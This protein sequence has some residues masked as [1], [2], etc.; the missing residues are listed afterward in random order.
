M[1]LIHYKITMIFFNWEKINKD[2]EQF[3]E[4]IKLTKHAIEMSSLKLRPALY[5]RE[6][7]RNYNNNNINVKTNTLKL[8]ILYVNFN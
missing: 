1:F 3:T 8:Q 2:I 6:Y 7:T 4:R 5:M